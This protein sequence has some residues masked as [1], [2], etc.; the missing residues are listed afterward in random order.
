MATPPLLR[1]PFH[2]ISGA[3]Q[4]A[5]VILVSVT[6]VRAQPTLTFKEYPQ[7]E[8][9]RPGMTIGPDGALWFTEYGL[10]SIGRITTSGI[11]SRF[12]LPPDVF[13]R[14]PDKI[15]TGPDGALWFTEAFG[16]RIGRITVDGAI[17]EFPLPTA[18]RNPRSITAGPDR[19]LWFTESSG[20][21]G[22][23]GRIT[24][25]GAVT[26]YEL[27]SCEESCQ[28]EPYGIA[29]GPDGALWFT[30]LYDSRI[31]RISTEGVFTRFGQFVS[32]VGELIATAQGAL[33]FSGG[34][35]A[36]PCDNVGRITTEGKITP[37]P[38]PIYPRPGFNRYNNL[39]P[40]SI[41]MGRDGA[42]WFAATRVNVVGRVART[43][44]V[45]L[46]PLP[47][48]A[49]DDENWILRAI[50]TGP[51][52]ALWIANVRSIVRASISGS[53]GG[54]QVDV[55]PASWQNRMTTTATGELRVAI[56]GTAAF[57]VERIDVSSIR[58]EG[59]PALS[60]KVENVVIG[61]GLCRAG[62]ADNR[63]DLRLTFS[64]P[65]ILSALSPLPET[66]EVRVL[67]LT[68]QL[69]P[70][71]GATPIHGKDFVVLTVR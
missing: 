30:N 41:T 12:P 21:I 60:A 57:D 5:A 11:V 66:S 19:A 49:V 52:G 71:S 7:P 65:A 36:G 27:P 14:G 20:G 22:R 4:M 24:T 56:L 28:Q 33:W 23:I 35:S 42:L 9:H 6:A 43:G 46:Y 63:P 51:D 17:T 47:G 2:F 50:T 58:L 26:E 45:T 69:E 54:V 55:K 31:W 15:T 61:A 10:D 44:R 34:D 67:R 25:A 8:S 32:Q 64:I 37:F 62:G 40:L 38:L 70:E 1:V 29:A 3:L 59:V 18:D 48:G 39:A 68:G 53:P 13:A 16:A